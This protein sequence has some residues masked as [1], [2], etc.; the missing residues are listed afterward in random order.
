MINEE[1]RG[2][3]DSTTPIPARIPAKILLLRLPPLASFRDRAMN[4]PPPSP[5][6][7]IQVGSPLRL[8]LHLDRAS[9]ETPTVILLKPQWSS[10][11]SLDRDPT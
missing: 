1:W 4:L 7:K 6:Q 3:V 9:T 8:H 5:S 10:Y 2:E 11:L